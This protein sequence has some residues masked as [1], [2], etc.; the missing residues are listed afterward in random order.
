MRA[1]H[2]A[3]LWMGMLACSRHLYQLHCAMFFA[4]LGHCRNCKH[5]K[6]SRKS[7][8]LDRIWYS[9]LCSAPSRE[10]NFKGIGFCFVLWGFFLLVCWLGFY[11]LVVV[12]VVVVIVLVSWF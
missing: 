4:A 9:H 6:I 1:P 12:V 3:G 2:A 5:R 10:I 11:C 8:A 7:W